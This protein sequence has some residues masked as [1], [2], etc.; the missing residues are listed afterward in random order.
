MGLIFACHAAAC[1]Q[2][3]IRNDNLVFRPNSGGFEFSVYQDVGA[4]EHTCVWFNYDGT[5]VSLDNICLDEGSDWYA[6]APGD[7]FSRATIAAGRFTP[8]VTFGPVGY[9]PAFVGP[10]DFSLGVS[11]GIGYDIP[12]DRTVFGW[13]LLRP[14]L[15]GLTMVENAMSYESQGI[16]VGTVR[17]VPEPSAITLGLEFIPLLF[18]RFVRTDTDACT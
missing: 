4:T 2:T 8:L 3:V 14:G 13:V 15:G 18:M 6:V 11:T 17:L 7:V 9:P 12:R 10:G 1:G 16:L 5:N